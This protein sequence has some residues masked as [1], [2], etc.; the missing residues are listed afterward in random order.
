MRVK[1]P[2]CRTQV[3]TQVRT[4]SDLSLLFSSH[5]HLV[6]A[7]H[8]TLL[9][10]TRTSTTRRHLAQPENTLNNTQL[11]RRRIQT[12]HSQPVINDHAGANDGRAAVHGSS[13]EGDLQERRELVLVADGGFRV[14]EAAL[15]GE[16]HV[17][18]C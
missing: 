15:V 1:S 14:H 2:A 16:G 10:N 9:I 17:G 5:P 13:D 18:A 4:L 7:L 8:N 6:E 12:R 3:R 11:R